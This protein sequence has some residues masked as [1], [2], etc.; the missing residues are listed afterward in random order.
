V[1][2]GIVKPFGVF[3]CSE[4]FPDLF[5]SYLRKSDFNGVY[6]EQSKASFLVVVNLVCLSK[7]DK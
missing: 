7:L 3:R 5:G 4:G 2:L 6:A 1:F